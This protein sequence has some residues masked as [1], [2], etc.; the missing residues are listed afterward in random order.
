MRWANTRFLSK[1][2]DC[3]D[4]KVLFTKKISGSSG[5]PCFGMW[6]IQSVGERDCLLFSG[7]LAGHLHTGMLSGL[8]MQAWVQL[9]RLL[10]AVWSGQ[11]RVEDDTE[12]FD[13]KGNTRALA[14]W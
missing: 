9:N 8:E 11:I 7:E 10:G 4:P 5:Q 13:S 2:V 12:G 6:V 14:V 3:K 1:G